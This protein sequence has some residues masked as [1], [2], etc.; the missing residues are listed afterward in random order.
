MKARYK[1]L[2]ENSISA[3]LSAIEIYNKPDFKYRNEIFVILT[4]NAWELLLKSK[5]LKDN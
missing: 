3:I 5:I 4:V 1:H 2:L